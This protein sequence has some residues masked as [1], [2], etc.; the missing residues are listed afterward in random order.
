MK[1]LATIEYLKNAAAYVNAAARRLDAQEGWHL[2]HAR[3]LIDQAEAD[4]LLCKRQI[5]RVQVT[6]AMGLQG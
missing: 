2:E 1:M 6:R 3:A 4:L 5:D